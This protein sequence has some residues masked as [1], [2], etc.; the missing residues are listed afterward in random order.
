RLARHASALVLRAAGGEPVRR[1]ARVGRTPTDRRGGP[2]L[3]AITRGRAPAA[4]SRLLLPRRAQARR[5][6]AGL[7]ALGQPPESGLLEVGAARPLAE[8][9]PRR[10]PGAAAS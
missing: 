7:G 3:G 9:S 4:G 5:V 8:L 10:N 2:A 1:R 6:R